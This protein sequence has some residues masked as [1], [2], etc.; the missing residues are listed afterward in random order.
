MVFSHFAQRRE[1]KRRIRCCCDPCEGLVDPSL[2]MEPSRAVVLKISPSP[3]YNNLTS[4]EEG[5]FTFAHKED[6]VVARALGAVKLTQAPSNTALVQSVRADSIRGRSVVVVTNKL[7]TTIFDFER[8]APLLTIPSDG[9]DARASTLL[10]SFQD[11]C[12]VLI[13]YLSGEVGVYQLQT[14]D[15]AMIA[16][17]RTPIHGAAVTALACGV[18]GTGVSAVSGD[19]NGDLRFWNDQL[20]VFAS[21]GAAGDCVTST[22]TFG[23]YVAAAYG[24]GTVR[25]YAAANAE[26]CVS[27]A[28]HSRWINAMAYCSSLNLLATVGEDCLVCVWSMPTANDRRIQLI[29]QHVEPNRLLTG[30]AFHGKLM[31]TAAY[32]SD[33]LNTYTL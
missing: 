16:S 15:L 28:A 5:C 32:D 1:M 22:V 2:M 11:L 19:V 26:L 29:K 20:Q 4:S 24:S 33:Y 17:S 7:A 6:V 14:V 25:L 27:I 23:F 18:S 31:A 10:H 30:V 21:Q 9:V 12:V 3:I 8:D 13:G